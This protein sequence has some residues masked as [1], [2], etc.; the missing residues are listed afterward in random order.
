MVVRNAVLFFAVLAALSAPP[1]AA[2]FSNLSV[3]MNGGL[4]YLPLDGYTG[5]V[6]EYNFVKRYSANKT[7][8]AFHAGF[9]VRYRCGERHAVVLSAGFIRT[10]AKFE[11][12][13]YDPMLLPDDPWQHMLLWTADVRI[14]GFP[15][16]LTYEYM[17]N[18]PAGRW[19][20]FA[21]VG[22]A[23]YFTSAERK[24]YMNYGSI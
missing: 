5:Q 6:T 9:D 8:S 13:Y 23:A 17:L 3:S 16:G 18:R 4:A 12:Y 10:T 1:A 20:M 22:A 14:T 15:V 11:E 24:N 21:G 19:G 2:Q 7:E